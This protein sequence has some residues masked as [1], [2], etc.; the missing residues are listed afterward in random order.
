MTIR[1]LEYFFRPRSVAVIGASNAPHSVGA[2]IMR[3]LLEAPFQGSVF[4]VNPQH[5]QIAGLNCVPTVEALESA[6]DLAV[7]CT[8]PATIPTLIAALGARGTKAAIVITAGLNRAISAE[9]PPLV[10]AMLAAAAPHLLRVLGPNCLGML[11]PGI[12][13]NA[14]FAQAQAIPG[15]LAFVSQSG[16]LATAVLDWGNAK[17]I[18]FS[19][20]IS[21]GDSVDVDLGDLLDYLGRDPETSAILLYIESIT[22]A[23]KFMSAARAAARAKPVIAVKAG[24]VI[25][26][27]RAAT[28]HTGALAGNDEIVDA[29]LRRAGILRVFTTQELFDAAETLAYAKAIRG[30]RLAIVTNG[31]GAGVLATDALISSGGTLAEL[32]PTTLAELEKVLPSTWSRAN[33]V[34]IIGDAPIERYIAALETVLADPGCDAALLLHAPTAIVPSAG[35]ATACV[36]VIQRS[37]KN[38]LTCFLGAQSV[39]AAR[40]T[41]AEHHVPSYLTPEAAIQAFLHIDDFERLQTLLIETPPASMLPPPNDRAAVR[42]IIDTALHAAR[43]LLAE[44][45]VRA[46][47]AAYA[48]PVVRT[49][50]ASDIEQAVARATAIGFPV[51]LKILSP[52]ISHKS[53]V[54]GVVL[55]LMSPGD[56][57]NAATAIQERIARSHPAARLTGFT[58]QAMVDTRDAC[59]LIAGVATDAVFGPVLMLGHGGTGVEVMKDRTFGLPP[60]N[61]PLARAMLSHTRVAK[62]LAGYRG[63]PAVDE[64]AV[65]SVMTRLSALVCEVPEIVELD[66]NPLLVTELGVLALDARI[67]IAPAC[68][69]ADSR[70]AI[71][72]YPSELQRGIEIA[73]EQLLLRPIRPEDERLHTQFLCALDPSDVYFRFF[74]AVKDWPH[75]QVAR[76][77]QIDYDR[78]MALVA[79]ANPQSA[80]TAIVGV[81]RCIGTPD[82]REAEFAIVIR[83]DYQGQGLGFQLIH[84]L[85][86]YCRQRQTGQLY[87]Y[88]LTHNRAM[89]GLAET[90][91]FESIGPTCGGVTK[92]ALQTGRI[93]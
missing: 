12:G 7:I 48:I 22:A 89:L 29:A 42:S 67:A 30:R 68:G 92:I 52:D 57:R 50:T 80:E 18:G 37:P 5:T 10:Q 28:S 79:V 62:L 6:P 9:G 72:P 3:N 55:N 64:A 2:L 40:A 15:K 23:R 35:I 78:E 71:R 44:N 74:H 81:A 1:N 32:A 31:G 85:I 93:K 24:R 73:G 33:P 27:A 19:C 83:H 16:A 56:V 26:G 86:D 17:G 59:E 4:P 41:F 46:L 43:T 66:I 70:L 54:G 58:V 11:V 61:A 65:L 69:T 53:D 84:A 45:E 21:L 90:C 14:S 20:F 88:V 49:E 77:T 36:P 91:G 47:L 34:D 76:L 13:L 75:A 63:R 87:G 60:L 25:E 51:A 82:N 38:T 8:P 39:M